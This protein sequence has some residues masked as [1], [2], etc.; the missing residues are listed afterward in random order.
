MYILPKSISRAGLTVAAASA[1]AIP[2]V[3]S[4]ILKSEMAF[5][6]CFRNTNVIQH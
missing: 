3:D 4:E 2:N 5:D 6:F 1:S